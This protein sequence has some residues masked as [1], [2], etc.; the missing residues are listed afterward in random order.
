LVDSAEQILQEL[1]PQLA[2]AKLPI[3]DAVVAATA[4]SAAAVAALSP[5]EQ[6]LLQAAGFEPVSL[7]QLVLRAGLPV[8]QVQAELL[9]LELQGW[10]VSV[11]G[12]YQ[13]LVH[14]TP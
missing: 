4:A 3:D 2:P 14:Q 10:I 1:A 6:R 8:A 9:S 13:R 7:D 5:V 11:A 12:G